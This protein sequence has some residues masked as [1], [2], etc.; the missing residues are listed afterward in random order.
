MGALE[1]RR[2]GGP[3]EGAHVAIR[4]EGPAMGALMRS[5][6][7]GPR[8]G[9][10]DLTSGG[11]VRGC[12]IGTAEVIQGGNISVPRLAGGRYCGSNFQ[13]LG[14]SRRGGWQRGVPK[15]GVEVPP[16]P[17]AAPP[18]RARAEELVEGLQWHHDGRAGDQVAVA[19]VH[20]GRVGVEA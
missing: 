4:E 9:A 3:R 13:E 2:D 8:G 5:G 1:L 16:G 12:G 10:R 20:V 7:R 14:L 19:C 17:V 15:A 18:E 6:E 11:G